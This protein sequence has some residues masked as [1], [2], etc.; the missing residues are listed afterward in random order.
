MMNY[1]THYVNQGW[2]CPICKTVYAPTTPM[3]FRCSGNASP[4]TCDTHVP[5]DLPS[6]LNE[7]DL[8]N[9]ENWQ[10]GSAISQNSL[11]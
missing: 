3:C 8:N 5:Y 2:Q 7:S 6:V 11:N 9:S 10:N 4:I 1:E